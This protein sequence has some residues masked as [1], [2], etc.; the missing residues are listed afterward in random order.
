MRQRFLRRVVLAGLV[1]TLA[2]GAIVAV[3]TAAAA[4]DPAKTAPVSGNEFD[5]F[6]MDLMARDGAVSGVGVDESGRI[7]VGAQMADL[8]EAMKAELTGYANVVLEDRKPPEPKSLTDVVGAAGY[9][10]A[11]VCSFG[12]S[13][14]SPT[15]KPAMVTAGHCVE[16]G[17][18]IVRTAPS[19]DDASFY[20][21][22][23]PLG[24]T[25][26]DS[27]PL[28]KTTF[29]QTGAPA[30]SPG[31]D[32]AAIDVTNP[33]LTP[34]P[35]VTDWESAFSDDLSLS[36]RAVTD[37]GTAEAGD[38]ITFAGRRSGQHTGKILDA[39]IYNFGGF[40]L[41]GFHAQVIALRGDS[42]GPFM[43]G[44]TALGTLVGGT[45]DDDNYGADL[46]T[47]LTATGGYSI[48]LAAPTV[49]SPAPGTAVAPGSSI[50]GSAPAGA[51]VE[52]T[53]NG[54]APQTVT[55][56]ADGTWSVAAPSTA[57]K[58]D[59]SFRVV[60]TMSKGRFGKSAPVAL[61]VTVEG[62]GVPAPTIITP[63]GSLTGAP[64]TITGTGEPGATVTVTV[65]GRALPTAVVRADGTWSVTAPARLGAG[66]HTITATQSVDGTASP[67]VTGTFTIIGSST[68]PPANP[69]GTSGNGSNGGSG[70]EVGN[71]GRVSKTDAGSR[72]GLATTGADGGLLLGTGIVGTALAVAATTFLLARRA[73]A[74]STT[75]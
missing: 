53:V 41:K 31:V 57:G 2:G 39:G 10:S 61:S 75:Q 65:D 42:G 19:R 9:S 46:A 30:G 72:R 7:V 13:A 44:T 63:S 73:R 68:P 58:A 3:P 1:V 54:G 56:G 51:V 27:A 12:F 17:D 62:T 32:I 14:W 67:T 48:M 43:R 22:R 59:F 23:S 70:G 45:K 28:G 35:F 36:G 34:K 47:G 69:A 24:P 8:S 20:P 66:R 16:D 29:S 74:R 49:S 50:S 21:E 71:I 38:T 6:A 64:T 11:G 33:A 15:D 60:D 25:G 37:V 18:E 55:A 52:F 5:A 26:L 40:I 4:D